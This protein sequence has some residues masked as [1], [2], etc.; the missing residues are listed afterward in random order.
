MALVSAFRETM[1]ASMLPSLPAVMVCSTTSEKSAM[2]FDQVRT[3]SSGPALQT[4]T[5]IRITNFEDY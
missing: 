2:G 4:P 3:F 5:I 1:A